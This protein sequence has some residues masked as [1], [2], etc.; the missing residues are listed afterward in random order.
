MSGD[1]STSESKI[2]G[3]LILKK[4]LKSFD[5]DSNLEE[6]TW[7]NSIL[8]RADWMLEINDK[9]VDEIS[10]I[11]STVVGRKYKTFSWCEGCKVEKSYQESKN[12]AKKKVNQVP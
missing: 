8:N 5:L 11:S 12:Q 3:L 2:D 7:M 4:C 10:S 1:E 6:V 9:W